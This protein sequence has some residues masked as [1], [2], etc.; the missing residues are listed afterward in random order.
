MT[1]AQLTDGVRLPLGRCVSIRDEWHAEISLTSE[2]RGSAPHAHVHVHAHVHA[3]VEGVP[4]KAS[5]DKTV[6]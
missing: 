4:S 3:H 5:S 2:T 6:F 1:L